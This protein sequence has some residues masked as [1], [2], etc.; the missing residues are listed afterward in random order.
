MILFW[1]LRN[2]FKKN[3]FR[4]YHEVSQSETWLRNSKLLRIMCATFSEISSLETTFQNSLRANYENFDRI[5]DRKM[6]ITFKSPNLT[7]SSWPYL[8]GKCS[9]NLSRV[10]SGWSP[11]EPMWFLLILFKIVFKIEFWAKFMIFRNIFLFQNNQQNIT[12]NTQ[13]TEFIRI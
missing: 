8:V 7:N 13:A 9:R 1:L 10:V 12:N 5:E 2:Q 11:M 3:N 6:A 4:N